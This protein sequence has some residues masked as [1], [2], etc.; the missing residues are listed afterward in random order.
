MKAVVYDRYG[1]R[2]VLR[3]EEVPVPVPATGQVLVR[4]AATSDWEAGARRR[5]GRSAPTAHFEPLALLCVD[6]EV[7]I[8]IDRTFS[9]EEVPEALARVGE[10]RALGKVV[11]TPGQ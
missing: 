6:G 4:V 5:A 9:L 8:E 2:D 11:V 1:P 7:R 3:V 10:G